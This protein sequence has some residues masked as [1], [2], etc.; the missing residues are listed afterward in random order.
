MEFALLLPA[1]TLIIVG[2]M[3]FGL[4]FNSY[5]EITHAAREGV[6]WAALRAPIS[7]VETRARD[8]AP[9]IDW[10][11]ATITVAGVPA[12]GATDGEQGDPATVTIIYNIDGIKAIGGTLMSFLPA[13]ISSAATQK[14]E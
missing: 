2:I 13:T 12:G 6:R 10:T 11:K 9:G 3:I 5:L 4:I 14:V 1:L 7:E 8:A